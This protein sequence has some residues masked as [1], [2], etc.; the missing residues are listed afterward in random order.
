MVRLVLIITCSILLSGCKMNQAERD[1]SGSLSVET[2]NLQTSERSL[3]F[4]YKVKNRMSQDAWVC[5]DVD[6]YSE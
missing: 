6:A 1:I 2:E 5:D 4:D 3:K